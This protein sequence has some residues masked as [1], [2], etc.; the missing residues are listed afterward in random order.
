ME[1]NSGM[2]PPPLL[3]L[4]TREEYEGLFNAIVRLTD[5]IEALEKSALAPF[6]ELYSPHD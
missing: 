1:Q 3:N 2:P 4:V 5:R 6:P